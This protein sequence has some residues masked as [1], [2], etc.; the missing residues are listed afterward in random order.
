MIN[1]HRFRNSLLREDSFWHVGRF[2]LRHFE[3][4]VEFERNIAFFRCFRLESSMLFRHLFEF[5]FVCLL[6]LPHH[7]SELFLG[8]RWLFFSH[9]ASRESIWFHL[10]LM[11][12]LGWLFGSFRF[13][14]DIRKGL[15]LIRHF[16]LLKS[17]LEEGN[18]IARN[19]KEASRR[20]FRSFKSCCLLEKDL[21]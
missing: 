1:D 15:S 16:H 19:W 14:F 11:Q 20:T 3:H 7:L 18:F 4:A 17:F 8:F 6:L 12:L 9:W 2:R 5:Q 21:W 10:L 13:L